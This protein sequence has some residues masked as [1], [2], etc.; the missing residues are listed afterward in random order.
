[1]NNIETAAGVIREYF[2]AFF[3][4]ALFGLAT[5][6]FF[7][8]G[9][10][11]E[12]IY[13][14]VS[15]LVLAVI[16]NDWFYGLCQSFGIKNEYYR[17]LW[18]VPVISGCALLVVKAKELAPGKILKAAVLALAFFGA[19]FL[20]KTYLT[21]AEIQLPENK[22]GV[23]DRILELAQALSDCRDTEEPVILC[24]EFVAL[25]I[26]QIDPS[27]RLAVGREAY[28][29]YARGES[30]GKLRR[31]G[32]NLA[33]T[34]SV[35]RKRRIKRFFKMQKVDYVIL[36]NEIANEENMKKY[37]CIPVSGTKDYTIF[38]VA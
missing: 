6:L 20:G 24:D 28:L 35:G 12:R 23:E 31:A 5:V 10:K 4:P 7:I 30:Q 34:G 19:G 2:G 11:R 25:R 1:M 15:L 22:Y 33:H 37:G 27:L 9:K 32:L 29:H 13:I 16:C 26:R 18:M 17:F 38:Q 8:R 21:E 36:S 14:G 3:F